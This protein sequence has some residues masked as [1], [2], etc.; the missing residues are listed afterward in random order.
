MPETKWKRLTKP[1]STEGEMCRHSL[2][3]CF[4]NHSAIF[5]RFTAKLSWALGC[6]ASFKVA[7]KAWIFDLLKCKYDVQNIWNQEKNRKF[8]WY[9]DWQPFTRRA[10]VYLKSRSRRFL[11]STARSHIQHSWNNMMAT[12]R[13]L[14]P[15]QILCPVC[16][17]GLS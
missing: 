14:L 2:P 16:H 6:S 15:L 3:F 5:V 12:T 7:D 17:E 11:F 4:F 8:I 9:L 1:I 13:E 10:L